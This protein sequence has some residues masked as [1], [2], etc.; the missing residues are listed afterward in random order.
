MSDVLPT[1]RLIIM[2]NKYML[3]VVVVVVHIISFARREEKKDDIDEMENV[4]KSRV[5]RVRAC[6]NINVSS[7]NQKKCDMGI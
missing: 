6:A 1:L 2:A 4:V 7:G 5:V 3:R